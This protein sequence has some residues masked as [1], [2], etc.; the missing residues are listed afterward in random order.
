M[1]VLRLRDRLSDGQI[2]ALAEGR[3]RG[4]ISTLSNGRDRRKGGGG[5]GVKWSTSKRLPVVLHEK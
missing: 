3:R 2:S 1:P 4:G 5:G